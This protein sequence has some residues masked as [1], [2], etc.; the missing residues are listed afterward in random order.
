MSLKIKTT[1][2]NQNSRRLHKP[3]ENNWGNASLELLIKEFQSSFI[4]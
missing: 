4:F 2:V 3:Q 1:L